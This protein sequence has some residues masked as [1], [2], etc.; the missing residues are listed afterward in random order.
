MAVITIV[1]VIIVL[2]AVAWVK[3]NHKVTKKTQVVSLDSAS[4]QSDGTA[5]SSRTDSTFTSNTEI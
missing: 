2:A 4:G 5:G 1:G 3:S